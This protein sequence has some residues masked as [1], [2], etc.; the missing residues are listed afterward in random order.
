MGRKTP[1][2]YRATQSRISLLQYK[3]ALVQDQVG[4]VVLLEGLPGAGKTELLS[5]FTART[6]MRT[7]LTHFTAAS[8]YNTKQSFGSWSMVLQQYLDRV[9]K[10]EV[11]AVIDRASI[12]RERL[13]TRSSGVVERPFFVC[14]VIM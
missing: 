5:V 6:L 3:I 11:C 12:V 9:Y 8:P 4:S 13:G 14:G 10:Q 7:A 2:C 1:R